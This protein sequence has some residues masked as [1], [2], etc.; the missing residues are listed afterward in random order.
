M[1]KA[2][3][4]ASPGLSTAYLAPVIG[5]GRVAYPCVSIAANA[6]PLDVIPESE[7]VFQKLHVNAETAYDIPANSPPERLAGDLYRFI[8]EHLVPQFPLQYFAVHLVADDPQNPSMLA[9]NNLAP[10]SSWIQFPRWD[11]RYTMDPRIV[12]MYGEEKSIRIAKGDVPEPI[13]VEEVYHLLDLRTPRS[14]EE[15]QKNYDVIQKAAHPEKPWQKS[16]FV[17]W[18]SRCAK[19]IL[20]VAESEVKQREY[21]AKRRRVEHF[22][23]DFRS[24][25]TGDKLVF[26]TAVTK[27][28]LESEFVKAYKA[29]QSPEDRYDLIVDYFNKSETAKEML[30]FYDMRRSDGSFYT[31]HAYMARRD[32]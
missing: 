23:I 12:K 10:A 27:E 11:E 5:S 13:T 18:M 7:A 9:T 17:K 6:T 15:A 4:P 21:Y 16:Y 28:E 24:P 31:D 3:V 29:A 30:E 2:I 25:F 32:L 26:Y 14:L 8:P 19:Y 20:E 1:A 22:P